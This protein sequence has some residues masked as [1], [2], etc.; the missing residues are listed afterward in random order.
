MLEKGWRKINEKYCLICGKPFSEE[1]HIIKRSQATFLI[2]CKL[3][4][5]YLCG[6]HHRS[7]IGVHGREGHALDLKL[8]SDFE[9]KLNLLFDRNYFTRE[10]IKK[11]LGISDRAVYSLCKLLESHKGLYNR[12]NII[13]AC[14]GR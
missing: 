5:V 11:T 6:T 13:R 9:D 10:E 8:K 14:M 1:H 7:E 4:K 12:E 3:N 2:N